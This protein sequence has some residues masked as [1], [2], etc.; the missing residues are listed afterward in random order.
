MAL[1]LT[2][3]G[4]VLLKIVTREEWNMKKLLLIILLGSACAGIF[5]DRLSAQVEIGKGLTLDGYMRYRTE[6]DDRDFSGLRETDSYST[7]R[8]RLGLKAEEIIESV[9][10]YLLIGDSRTLGYSDPY[11]EGSPIGPISYDNG[12]GV[13]EAYVKI[14]DFFHPSLTAVLGRMQFNHG[15]NRFFG[16]GNWNV[17]GPRRYD[18][19]YMQYA[20]PFGSVKAFRFWG[21]QGDRHWRPEPSNKD[22][23]LSG[24]DVRLLR[25]Q[26]QLLLLCD[27]D[28]EETVS[29]LDGS[30][31]TH[32][33]KYT[34]LGYYGRK[35]QDGGWK[36]DLDW[37]YQWGEQANLLGTSTI[38]AYMAAGDCAYYFDKNRSPWLGIGFDMTSGDDGS[39]PEKVSFF[40]AEYFSKHSFQ[41]QMDYFMQVSAKQPGL[42]SL[43]LRGGFAPDD[44][45]RVTVDIHSFMYQE[46]YISLMDGE[47]T[48]AIGREID[49]T[50]DYELRQG[51]SMSFGLDLFFPSDHWAGPDSESTLFSYLSLTTQF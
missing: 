23:M 1:I 32:L 35:Q 47:D 38:G 41:G 49:I 19:F 27:H 12:L 10:M 14:G 7:L 42:Q 44:R 16:P 43:I 29:I 3:K 2:C 40:T 8:T 9:T 13:T 22:H 11:L 39:D 17:N 18:G 48:H 45:S 31:N 37:A 36:V 20:V 33:K 51:I 24:I 34:F 6:W 4:K 21:M 28:A 50:A 5:G 30:K 46:P 26:L 25:E 15:R